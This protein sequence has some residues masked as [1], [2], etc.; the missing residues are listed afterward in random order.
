MV[1]S[2]WVPTLPVQVPI[3]CL[4]ARKD[5]SVTVVQGAPMA[6]NRVP[7]SAVAWLAW[8]LCAIS[9]TLGILGLVTAP[10]TTPR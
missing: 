4:Q 5:Q 7:A 9:A 2:A 1:P 8:T 10:G 3:A 6:R